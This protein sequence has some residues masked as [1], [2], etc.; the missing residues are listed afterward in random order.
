[1]FALQVRQAVAMMAVVT[2]ATTAATVTAT[3]AAVVPPHPLPLPEAGARLAPR[4]LP[5]VGKRG[6]NN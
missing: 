4:V 5:A 2:T 6:G 1:M 3:T